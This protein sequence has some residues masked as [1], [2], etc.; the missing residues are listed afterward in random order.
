M[1]SYERLVK[2]CGY[3][4]TWRAA[5]KYEGRIWCD[6]GKLIL[7]ESVLWFDAWEDLRPAKLW[8]DM[9]DVKQISSRENIEIPKSSVL[10]DKHSFP[11]ICS[12]S[13]L[14]LVDV[15]LQVECFLSQPSVISPDGSSRCMW[16]STIYSVDDS[17]TAARE[18]VGLTVVSLSHF[19]VGFLGSNIPS[20]HHAGLFATDPCWH[21]RSSARV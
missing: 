4:A 12:T 20:K 14:P 3:S 16:P 8:R 7:C 10:S 6:L 2:K 18:I 21:E 9:Q 1:R 11:G 19:R 17:N 13:A 15:E 5:G